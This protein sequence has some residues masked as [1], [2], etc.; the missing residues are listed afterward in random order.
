[1]CYHT[2]LDTDVDALAKRMDRVMLAETRGEL[3]FPRTSAFARPW[4][5]VVTAEEQHVIGWK[6]WGLV[7]KWATD[8]KEFLKRS[9]TYNAVSEEAYEKRSFK[10]AMA[11]GRRCLIPVTAFYEWQ[12]RP[13]EGRK[14][15]DKVPYRLTLQ[16]EGIFC[17]AGIYEGETYSILTRP[18]Q[19]LMAEIHNTKKRQ[20]VIIPRAFE[21]DWLNPAL[22]QEDVLRFCRLDEE[23]D[24]SAT[25]VEQLPAADGP[26]ATEQLLF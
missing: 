1:M 17:L 7:P 20:P 21:G 14:T 3:P 18:A 16:G 13:V 10:S 26:S 19:T 11:A 25:E 8:A 4:W 24:L 23:A 2:E 6:Q 15:P 12:H 9:P 5:P 22:E